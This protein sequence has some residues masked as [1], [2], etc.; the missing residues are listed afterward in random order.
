MSTS[1]AASRTMWRWWGLS[2]WGLVVAAAY[3]LISMSPSLLPRT[4]YLQ[5]AIS[6]LCV[7]AGYALGVVLGWAV[8]HL[9]ELLGLHVM[10]SRRAGHVLRDALPVFAAVAVVWL[11]VTNV[12]GQGRTAEVVH[13]RPLGP[14]DWLGAIVISLAVGAFF[15][16]L[17]R[18]LRRATDRLA[19]AAGRV[20]PKAIAW[21]T[22]VLVIV[23]ATAWISD[24]VIFHRGMQALAAFASQVNARPPADRSPPTSPFVSGGPGSGESYDSLGYQGQMFVT[25][26]P[27]AKEIES[28]TGRP[29]KEPIRAYAGRSNDRSIDEVA[30]A[31]L[32][33]LRRTGAFDRRVLAVI[34]TTGTGW[35]DDWSAQSIE[36]LSNGDSAIAAMQY[37]YLPSALSMMTDR[38]TPRQA[39]KALFDRIEAEWL[40]RPADRRPFLVVGGESLGSYGGQA[41]FADAEDM[42]RRAQGGVWVGTPSFTEIHAE[43]TSGRTPGSPEI[44][45]VVG[46]GQHIRFVTAAD[47][48]TK[49]YYGREYGQWD[50]P[51]FVYAQHP[52]D[53]VVWWNPSTLRSEPDWLREPR[54]RDV[55]PDVTWIP[56]A[57]F[58]QLSSDMAV[59][60][61]PP[62]GF[63]HRYGAELVAEWGAVLGG[64]PGQD[65]SAIIA[66]VKRTV[67]RTK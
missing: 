57:T 5:G 26:V 49:D 33:E 38:D 4:W 1:S 67:Y 52:S 14:L 35:V 3:F 45:P 39:G 44:A 66:G 17:A 42:L 11:T 10:V 37:S 22:A 36:Y 13:L 12:R 28:A 59:G 20:L 24:S 64:T 6:G 47:E 15:L 18:G 41:A 32:A 16:L 58:W 31:V 40:R 7:A 62:D 2:G 51:R 34:T 56:F 54:G 50:F 43:L 21:V 27:T 30:D 61:D 53:A 46:Q 48:L 9:T 19:E 63:G 29:A 25:N 55:N 65:Y 8:R 60:H 23:L